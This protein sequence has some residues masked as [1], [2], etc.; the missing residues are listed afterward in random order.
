MKTILG[1]FFSCSK[2]QRLIMRL[3]CKQLA[4]KTE[5]GWILI[6]KPEYDAA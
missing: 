6:A 5:S 2:L 1:G 3:G 4:E